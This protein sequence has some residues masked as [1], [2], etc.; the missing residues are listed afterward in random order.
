V[1]GRLCLGTKASYRPFNGQ[2]GTIERSEASVRLPAY[3]VLAVSV[4]EVRADRQKMMHV[5]FKREVQRSV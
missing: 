1:E 4:P 2:N 3:C 5:E